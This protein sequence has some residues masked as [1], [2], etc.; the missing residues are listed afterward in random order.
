VGPEQWNFDV[1][2]QLVDETA[3]DVTN[4]IVL[5]SYRYPATER[6]PEVQRLW[7]NNALGIVMVTEPSSVYVAGWSNYALGDVQPEILLPTV[8]IP[9]ATR[10]IL[11]SWLDQGKNITVRIT[12]EDKNAWDEMMHSDEMIFY[13]VFLS[14]FS[15]ACLGLAVYKLSMFIKSKGCQQSIPQTMLIFEIITNTVRL[16]PCAIDPLLSRQIFPFR[17]GAFFFT[18]SWPFLSINLL[19]LSFYWQELMLKSSVV[20]NTFLKKL[21]VPFW[22][23]FGLLLAIEVNSNIIRGFGFDPVISVLI[24]SGFYLLLGAF[25]V[26]YYIVTGTKLV[27]SL[28][29][30]TKAFVSTKRAKRLRQTSRFIYGVAFGVICWLAVISLSL[31]DMFWLPWGYFGIWFSQFFII[32]FISLMQQLAIQEPNSACSVASSRST[33]SGKSNKR[34]GRL[35]TKETPLTATPTQEV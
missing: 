31:T 14:A 19:L 25:C 6:L 30:A 13:S 5:F 12:S 28:N 16:I 26:V 27:L 33:A 32:T 21:K 4:K 15:A 22:V 9:E 29:R 3:A 23:I 1:V 34:S 10:A 35:S 24:V 11:L 20:I 2:G 7:D 17:F 8:M 18:M